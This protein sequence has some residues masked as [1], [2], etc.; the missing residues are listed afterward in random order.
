MTNFLI[1]ILIAHWM[2]FQSFLNLKRPIK[3][4]GS[5]LA[6]NGKIFMIQK[7]LARY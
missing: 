5:I 2:R 3:K 1:K 7:Y 6:K 4:S